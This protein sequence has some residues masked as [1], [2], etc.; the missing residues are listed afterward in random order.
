MYNAAGI[1]NI[2]ATPII[3][4]IGTGDGIVK[5]IT[6]RRMIARR[7]AI[8]NIKVAYR[9]SFGVGFLSH[10]PIKSPFFVFL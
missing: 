4:G 8:N 9:L 5:V 10:L 1:K 3:I 6:Y 2:S 7:V